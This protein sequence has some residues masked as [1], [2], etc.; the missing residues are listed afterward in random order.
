MYPKLDL[1]PK[2]CANGTILHELLHVLGFL[3]EHMRK[4]RN[5]YISIIDRNIQ[6]GTL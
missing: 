3:G 1:N 5:I 2:K 6:T 4:D